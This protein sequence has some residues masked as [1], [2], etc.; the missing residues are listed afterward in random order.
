M[1]KTKREKNTYS[2]VSNIKLFIPLLI[3]VIS[4]NLVISIFSLINIQHQNHEYI[5]NSVSLFQDETSSHINA[6]QH[7]MEWTI[8]Q[9]LLVNSLETETN[10]YEQYLTLDALQIRIANHQ[11]TTGNEFNYFLYLQP[12][13]NSIMFLI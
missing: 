6:I 9:E 3:F 7:F 10:D 11:Y 8:I 5:E 2:L 12:Q 1:R 4:I 13:G